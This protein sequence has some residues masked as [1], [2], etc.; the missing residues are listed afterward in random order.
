M[1]TTYNYVGATIRRQGRGW[2]AFLPRVRG[3]GRLRKYCSTLDDCRKWVDDNISAAR[4]ADYMPPTPGELAEFKAAKALLPAGRNLIDA[5]RH[6]ARAL[7][8]PDNCVSISVENAVAEYLKS[9][10]DNGCRQKT[11]YSYSYHLAR[12]PGDMP[13][14]ALDRAALEDHLEGFQ[15]RTRNNFV[16]DWSGFFAWCERRNYC[17]LNPAAALER[18]KVDKHPVQIYKPETVAAVLRHA[19]KNNRRLVPL[20]AIAAFAG[21]RSA[22]LV[23]L[24]QDGQPVVDLAR[25]LIWVCGGADKLRHGYLIKMQPN[26]KKWLKAY[27]FAPLPVSIN[28]WPRLVG[29]LFKAAEQEVVPNGFRHSFGSYLLAKTNDAAFVGAQMGQWSMQSLLAHYRRA[30][31]PSEARKYFS[32]CPQ[33]VQRFEKHLKTT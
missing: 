15:P 16:A 25:G 2:R 33:S 13:I 28:Y 20:L 6:Y 9:R 32:I 18:V 4:N 17:A 3:A 10:R 27:P 7:A 26:L 21:V 14:H 1:K 19:E 24:G 8:K 31:T 29:D 5:A 22:G 12:L 11:L 23:R 30:A